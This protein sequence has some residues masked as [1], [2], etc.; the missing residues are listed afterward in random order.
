MESFK[1][2]NC[3][4]IVREDNAIGT[5]HRNHCLYCLWSLH[6]D[7]A[8][9]GDRKAIC[10]GKMEPLG[11]TFKKEGMNKYGK[12]KEGEIMIIHKCIECGKISINRIAGDDD[13]KEI[14]D[15]FEKGVSMDKELKEEL[16]TNN[17]ILLKK[18]DKDELE[19]QLFGSS[20]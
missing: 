8:I 18:E 16:K 10:K 13:T 9:S 14:L 15:L 19:I 7:K 4:K 1:C 5:K 2:L 12:E 3:E 6:L 20:S 11:L 17:I